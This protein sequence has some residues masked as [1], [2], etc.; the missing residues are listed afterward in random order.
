MLATAS[1]GVSSVF[2]GTE[3]ASARCSETSLTARVFFLVILSLVSVIGEQWLVTGEKFL[4]AGYWD[5]TDHASPTDEQGTPP[6]DH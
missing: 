1:N 6:A 4:H 2:C 5:R 3:A